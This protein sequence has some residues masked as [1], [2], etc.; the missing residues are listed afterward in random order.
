MQL[1]ALAQAGAEAFEKYFAA[2][3]RELAADEEQLHRLVGVGA[4]AMGRIAARPAGEIHPG[5]DN[6]HLLAGHAVVVDERIFGP[7][8]PGDQSHGSRQR[9]PIRQEL[10]TFP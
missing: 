2:F 1:A 6:R 3:A 4:G 7:A 8:A 9:P 10:E 5:W